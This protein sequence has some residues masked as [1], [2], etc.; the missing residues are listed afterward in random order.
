MVYRLNYMVSLWVCLPAYCVISRGPLITLAV[1]MSGR[2]SW[3]HSQFLHDPDL[4]YWL[5]PNKQVL[6]GIRYEYMCGFG[7]EQQVTAQ[8]TFGNNSTWTGGCDFFLD[9]GMHFFAN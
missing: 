5:G 3:L 2:S 6:R 9:T 1:T 8:V 7:G 4:C